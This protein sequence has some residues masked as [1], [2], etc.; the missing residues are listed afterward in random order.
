MPKLTIAEAWPLLKEG[1]KIRT[2]AS[3]WI[4]PR[5]EDFVGEIMELS[6]NRLYAENKLS[7]HYVFR[8]NANSNFYIEIV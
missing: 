1:M 2:N 5:Y 4:H 6:D 7:S 8:K 3:G